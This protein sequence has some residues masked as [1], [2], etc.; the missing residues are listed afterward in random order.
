MAHISFSRTRVGNQPEAWQTVSVE[1]GKLARDLSKEH[2]IFAIVGPDAGDTDT[3]AL[4]YPTL[5]ELEVNT[6]NAFGPG[7]APSEV[8]NLCERRVQF[9]W[10]TATGLILHEAMHARHTKYDLRAIPADV[11]WI[12][13][14]FEESRIEARGAQHFPDMAQFLRAST[15][16]IIVK[17]NAT[18]LD[19]ILESGWFGLINL[20]LLTS[21]RIDAGVVSRDDVGIFDRI[22]REELPESLY[23]FARQ[24]WIR[25]QKHDSDTDATELIKIA[26]ELHTAIC[27]ALPDEQKTQPRIIFL[28]DP[29]EG[30]VP[31][32]PTGGAHGEGDGSAT[33][34]KGEGSDLDENTIII[35]LRTKLEDAFNET[36][37]A[38]QTAIRESDDVAQRE[39]D[40]AEAEARADDAKDAAKDEKIARRVFSQDHKSKGSAG[41]TNSRLVEKRAPS[42]NE[43]SAAVQLAKQL[44]KA[45]YRDR[46]VRSTNSVLPPGRMRGRAM[47]TQ[48]AQIAAGQTPTATP[49]R[50]KHR[51]HVDD[52]TLTI[53]VMVDISGSMGSAMQPMASAAWILSEA[54]R[55][56]DGRTAMVYFGESVFPVLR[57]GQHLE[58]VHVYT[59]PDGTEQF[60]TGFAAL[61]GALNLTRGT[62]ARL[63]FVV[64]DTCYRD[65]QSKHAREKIAAAVRAGVAV[66]MLD[67]TGHGRPKTYEKLGASYLNMR[68]TAPEAAAIEIGIA[69]QQALQSVR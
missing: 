42:A 27:D 64:S 35:D 53:G 1:V 16:E 56:I 2:D 48:T 46:E 24:C 60:S 67:I 54:A 7:T 21:A 39:R 43:R 13:E 37:D 10:P 33:P 59:A 32:A 51:K 36:E 49:W 68:G 15:L 31:E 18:K 11:R 26:R 45:R 41:A 69:A 30:E 5:G 19:E 55:R 34:S 14:M 38:A 28:V 61:D 40:E 44:D 17:E 8:G 22:I 47:V 20:A 52:P 50:A 63:L 29:P 3:V 66:T 57:P 12:V 6:N 58:K 25:A 65:E 62:G 4:F 9:N 23:D